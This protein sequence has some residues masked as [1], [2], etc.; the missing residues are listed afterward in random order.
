[1]KQARTAAMILLGMFWAGGL[2][3]AG[4]STSDPALPEEYQLLI[5][6]SGLAVFVLASLG[7]AA[8]G[9]KA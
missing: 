1:M 2:M 3:L 9:R 5:C 7:M 6:L 8:L 4:A